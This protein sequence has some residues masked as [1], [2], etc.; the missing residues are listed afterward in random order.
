M[1]KFR[2]AATRRDPNPSGCSALRLQQ[3][4]KSVGA[5]ASL[6]LLRWLENE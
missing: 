5:G 6:F 2:A 3:Q 4:N 1:R